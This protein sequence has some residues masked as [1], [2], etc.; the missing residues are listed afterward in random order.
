MI[1]ATVITRVKPLNFISRRALTV[2]AFGFLALTLLHIFIFDARPDALLYGVD[3]PVTSYLA[4]GIV[5]VAIVVCT[6]VRG[7]I[8]KSWQLALR[9]AGAS[10][11][12]YL[13]S[14]AIVNAFQPAG[15]VADANTDLD[16]AIRQTGQAILSGFWAV[17]GFGA[18]VYGLIKRKVVVRM[19]GLALLGL[20]ITKVFLYDLSTL[21]SLYRVLSF[22]ALGL[23][24]LAGALAYQRLRSRD[25]DVETG[26][27]RKPAQPSMT[28]SN[29]LKPL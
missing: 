6:V 17:L 24:L 16:L 5:S 13:C 29:S 2:G 4:L 15:P 18:L 26:P 25:K 10:L 14:I 28:I 20:T 12:V 8:L 11:I 19:F 3:H 9:V 23:L 7:S 27:E 21:E 22:I 1:L